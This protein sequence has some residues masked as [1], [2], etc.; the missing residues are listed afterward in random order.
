[1]RGRARAVE[2][3]GM[4]GE[5]E[6]RKGKGRGVGCW[7]GSLLFKILYVNIKNLLLTKT[8]EIIENFHFS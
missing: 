6:E 4:A 1:M 8:L 3:N 2:E 5:E 7:F